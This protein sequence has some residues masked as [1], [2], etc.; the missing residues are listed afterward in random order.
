[1]KNIL[2]IYAIL[3]STF[4]A[5]NVFSQANTDS[6]NAVINNP[7]SKNIDVARAYVEMS[8]MLGIENL[9]SVIILCTK[10]NVIIEKALK[11]EKD[12][13]IRKE[14]LDISAI[15][16]S[17]LGIVSSY[18]GNVKKSLEYNNKSLKIQEKLGNIEGVAFSLNNIATI[19]YTQG[20]KAKALDYFNQSLEVYKKVDNKLGIALEL[21]NIG[22]YYQNEG[23]YDKAMEYHMESLKL[24]EEINSPSNIAMSLHNIGL[25]HKLQGNK[26]LA[27]E[28]YSKALEIQ[29]QIRD[30][31]GSVYSLN[32]LGDIELDNG[33]LAKA[34]KYFKEA[35]EFSNKIGHP[36]LIKTTARR[37]SLVLKQ[38][39]RGIEALEMYELYITMRDSLN[40]KET[41]KA[42]AQQQAKYEYE[43]KKAIDDAEHEKIILI[44][45]QDKEKQRVITLAVIGVLVLVSLFLI[46]VFYKLRITKKQKNEIGKQK[47]E[48]EEKSKEITDSINYAKRIQKAIL[49]PD[50]LI[51]KYLKDSFILYKPK[52]IV[53][54]DFYWM[55]PKGD[56]VLFAV[57]D[58]TGHGVPGAMVSVIC[59]NAL[60]R[61]VREYGLVDTGDIL[62]KTRE[63][64]IEEFEKSDEEVK[65]GMDI[66]LIAFNKKTREIVFSGANN[67][68]WI[69]RDGELIEIK[70]D[71]QPVGKFYKSHDFS[72]HKE[73]LKEGDLIYTFSD[74][75][76][77]Q[78]GGDN[79]KKFKTS[80]F[81]KLLL[82]IN[83]KSI[84]EQEEIISSSFEDWKGDYEQ[85]D[86]VCVMG[87]KI[88]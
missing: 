67:P 74:G 66:S 7:D 16:Y 72:S 76:A 65:D 15:S 19:Y 3:I 62:N 41:L 85:L 11:K 20:S 14:L 35:F 87:L 61:S 69:V 50:S 32:H 39:N 49:P 23:D 80:N 53:A 77:D 37:M 38:Q 52:D 54:G 79:D 59:N 34:E 70:G 26:K 18:K 28:S 30:I 29:I 1:M 45:H 33:N 63:I 64:V 40:N 21:N 86:D 8:D 2:Y 78:F 44:E 6:L 57:A 22:Y 84:S 83:D 42:T 55:E 47:N 82:S 17:N 58:C 31:R 27:L 36:E 9:D 81:K 4:C 51:K 46:F 60:N 12:A 25:I 75:Y 56:I 10:S 73:I 24:R 88:N 43:N 71:R 48:I 13:T 5:N 68:L